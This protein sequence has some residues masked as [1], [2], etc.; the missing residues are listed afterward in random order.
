MFWIIRV[1]KSSSVSPGSVLK[2]PKKPKFVIHAASDVGISADGYRWRK[3]GQ[4]MV[5]GNP[6][7][8]NYYKCTSTGCPVRKHIEMAVDDSSEVILTYK[9]IH[10]H[11][12][13][14]PPKDQAPPN[15]LLT[16]ISSPSKNSNSQSNKGETEPSNGVPENK[17]KP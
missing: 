5:K 14:T 7:P 15:V 3:Y 6:H 16:A 2:S 13:P 11:E 8:R 10:D 12:I 9:G 17:I 4:K 1:K